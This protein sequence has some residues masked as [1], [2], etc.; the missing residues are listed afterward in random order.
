VAEEGPYPMSLIVSQDALNRLLR[1]VADTHIDPL[2]V[3]LGSALGFDVSAEVSPEVPLIQ[4]EAVEGCPTCITAEVGFGLAVSAAGFTIGAEGEARFQLPI[5]MEPEGLER[6]RVFGDFD[7][8][9]FERVDIRVRATAPWSSSR[10]T[11]GRSATATSACSPT[12][13]AR[14]PPPSPSRPPSPRAPTSGC[15]FTPSWCR[16]F[17]NLHGVVGR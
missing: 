13:C 7:R 2:D 8:S 5:R 10:S 15:R 9:T 6:T 4:I 11:P 1:E 16:F 14:S 12:S 17:L 3:S